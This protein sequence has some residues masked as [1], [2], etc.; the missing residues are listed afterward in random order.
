M[1]YCG[2]H[3]LKRNRQIKSWI[4]LLFADSS[5][6][7]SKR[8]PNSSISFAANSLNSPAKAQILKEWT[9]FR[10]QILKKKRTPFW[11]QI[12][13]KWRVFWSEILSFYFIPLSPLTS[14][15]RDI[16]CTT[17]VF[18]E[19]EQNRLYQCKLSFCSIINMHIFISVF[20]QWKNTSDQ[21]QLKKDISYTTYK[22]NNFSYEPGPLWQMSDPT[23]S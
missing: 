23:C 3:N 4:H 16:C 8:L 7:L 12:L 20:V 9:L 15:R 14:N 5:C 21:L 1:N 11:S 19:I 17:F 10:S 13:K 2:N 6:G 22:Q 18:A